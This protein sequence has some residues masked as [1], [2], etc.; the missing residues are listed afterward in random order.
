MKRVVATLLVL[1][2]CLGLCGCGAMLE[3]EYYTVKEHSQDY[4]PV[5]GSVALQ[6]EDYNGLQS[7]MIYFVWN[8]F[9]TGTVRLNNYSGDVS[10]DM[11]AARA[12][13][14]REDALGAYCVEDI[15]FNVDQIVSYYEITIQ[16]TYCHTAQ[17]VESIISVANSSEA[18]EAIEAAVKLHQDQVIL[19]MSYFL[20]WEDNI[21]SYCEDIYY[22]NPTCA[23]MPPEISYNVYPETGNQR[24]IE[25][26]FNYKLDDETYEKFKEMVA[27]KANEIILSS[28]TDG[29]KTDP[30]VQR[31]VL[32]RFYNYLSNNVDY[33]EASVLLSISGD[34]WAM[35]LSYTPFGALENGLA[36]GEGTALT[37]KLLCDQVGI[38]CQVVRGR[39][40]YY[41]HAWNIVCVDGIYYHVDATN[42]GCFMLGNSE[43]PDSYA[44][45]RVKY[46]YCRGD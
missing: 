19:K 16:I 10:E 42:S 2:T 9:D 37:Y 28:D 43:M 27:D 3:D 1:V 31:T 32:E 40:N 38:D 11:S 35:S 45:N 5:E 6:A 26:L 44:W 25:I 17:E 4:E 23:L 41:D 8:M 46:P 39:R 30:N 12:Y 29:V 18:Y 24:I 13:I 7:A 14:M 36:T 22:N 33:D 20:D 15:L 34:N 21:E